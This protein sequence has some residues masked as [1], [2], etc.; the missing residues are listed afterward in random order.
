MGTIFLKLYGSKGIIKSILDGFF[1][2]FFFNY[3]FVKV[4]LLLYNKKNPFH[5]KT[6]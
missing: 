2:M 1:T 4:R 3:I 6:E 5:I